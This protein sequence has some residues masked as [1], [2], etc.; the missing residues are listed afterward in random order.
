M[1]KIE[2]AYSCNIA[3][4]FEVFAG[5]WKPEIMWHLKTGP[6][7]FNTLLKEMDG[8]S[9]KM[10]TQ[11]LREM[12]RDGLVTR[13]DYFEKPLRVE[14]TSTKLAESLRPIFSV[15]QQWTIEHG[16]NVAQARRLYDEESKK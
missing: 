9:Q 6:L 15:L 4:A 10:L 13:T 1:S 2:Q 5:K 11:Q 8:I 3:D 7:R 14:Y 12:Q 16:E